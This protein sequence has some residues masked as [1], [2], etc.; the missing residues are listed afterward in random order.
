MQGNLLSYMNEWMPLKSFGSFEDCGPFCH[1]SELY[2]ACGKPIT[3][4]SLYLQGRQCY[5][6][7]GKL[8]STCTLALDVH[9]H[10]IPHRCYQDVIFPTTFKILSTCTLVLDVNYELQEFPWKYP[11]PE[12][13]HGN[14]KR[15][16]H[17]MTN[18]YNDWYLMISKR[19]HIR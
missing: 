5:L 17:H 16:I 4:S 6:Q 8:P 10:I 3:L 7:F 11:K 18:Y 1:N 2:W 15:K 19:H 9:R 12:K 14:P 13:N